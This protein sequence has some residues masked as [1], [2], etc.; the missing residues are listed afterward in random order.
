MRIMTRSTLGVLAASL[1]GLVASLGPAP[2]ASAAQSV[3]FI[4]SDPPCTDGQDT[5]MWTAPADVTDVTGYHVVQ[6][7]GDYSPPRTSTADLPP[8]QTSLSFTAPFGRTTVAVYTMTSGGTTSDPFAVGSV[9]AGRAPAP[10]QWDYASGA[11]VGDGTATVPFR[12]GQSSTLVSLT[13]AMPATLAVTTSPGAAQQAVSADRYVKTLT[14]SGLKNGTTYTFSP[15]TSNACGTAP[16]GPSA[17]YTPGIR[18]TWLTDTPP[19]TVAEPG[20]YFYRFVASGDPTP[21]LALRDAPSWLTIN[22][23]GVV[24]GRP[25]AGTSSFSYSV[26]ARNGVGIAYYENP[27]VV[28]G[29]FTVT[30]QAR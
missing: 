11:A 20:V 6:F 15:V 25:P 12:W 27:D 28:A 21:R 14:F 2:V 17:Q 22:P 24:T 4:T 19:L 13:G 16:G 1:S 7:S 9:V 30:V 18:P 29:P 3:A 23:T 8:T 26:V 10:M 5:A